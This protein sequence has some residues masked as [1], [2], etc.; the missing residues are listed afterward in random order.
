MVRN[1]DSQI[2]FP[3]EYMELQRMAHQMAPAQFLLNDFHA[4]IKWLWIEWKSRHPSSMIYFLQQDISTKKCLMKKRKYT[5]QLYTITHCEEFLRFP[6]PFGYNSPF[7]HKHSPLVMAICSNNLNGIC[8]LLHHGATV[9]EYEM[10]IAI[11][12]GKLDVFKTLLRYFKSKSTKLSKKQRE[13]VSFNNNPEFDWN[14]IT[15]TTVNTTLYTM[16][17]N[18]SIN[19][20]KIDF[21]A[22]LF[23]ADGTRLSLIMNCRFINRT[24]LDYCIC[25]NKME[26]VQFVLDEIPFSNNLIQNEILLSVLAHSTFKTT[27]FLFQKYPNLAKGII[28]FRCRKMSVFLYALKTRKISIALML[29][30]EFNCEIPTFT[31]PCLHLCVQTMIT[32][33]FKLSTTSPFLHSKVWLLS[34]DTLKKS[35][36][37]VVELIVRNASLNSTIKGKTLLHL[38][39]SRPILDKKNGDV[40]RVNVVKLLIDA[41]ISLNENRCGFTALHNCIEFDLFE[42]ASLLINAGADPLITDKYGLSA[43]DISIRTSNEKY[44]NLFLLAPRVSKLTHLCLLQCGG[45][46]LPLFWTMTRY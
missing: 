11:R 10:A 39:T 33:R 1:L 9:G 14:K 46:G 7:L 32:T 27:R 23:N 42:I 5:R 45:N 25:W 37:L 22:R 16:K 44:L 26:I 28:S 4:Q 34:E 18:V 38:L 41:G 2:N 24:L 31:N 8:V 20:P 30:Q 13:R 17:S 15:E 29:L 21:T 36:Q 35:F 6:K 40:W 43:F 3:S 12:L 19:Q